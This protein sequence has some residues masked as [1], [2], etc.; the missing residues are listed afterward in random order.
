[1]SKFFFLQL[2]TIGA[3]SAVQDSDQ[4]F[5]HYIQY[6]FTC[7]YIPYTNCIYV[8]IQIRGAH[9]S[10]CYHDLLWFCFCYLQRTD[11]Q[12]NKTLQ[13]VYIPVQDKTRFT[14][15]VNNHV[16]GPSYFYNSTFLVKVV[17]V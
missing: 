11:V 10:L 9:C 7:L 14:I 8:H 2:A 5:L 3:R 13:P 15:L 1:M 4:L 6:L 16:G 17:N 12:T